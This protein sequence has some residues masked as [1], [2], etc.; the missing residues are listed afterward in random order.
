[1]PLRASWNAMARVAGRT[2]RSLRR[3]VDAGAR[4]PMVYAPAYELDLP[5]VPIDPLRGEK[6]LTALGEAGVISR[7]EIRAAPRASL[8]SLCR[9]HDANYVESLR[10][11][12]ALEGVMGVEVGE[13]A[14]QAIL[15]HQRHMVG[16]TALAAGIARSRGGLVVNVGGGLHH[17]HPGRGHGFCAFNDVAVAIGELRDRG[18]DLRVLVVDLDIH[19]G[20]GTRAFFRD[21][22]Q[23]HTFSIHNDHWG[24]T[25]AVESTSLAL[26]DGVTDQEYLATLRRHLPRV[27]DRFRPQL[28][29][30][31]AGADP[32][33]SD[34]L[35]NWDITDDG[36]LAR[37]RFVLG[38]LRSRRVE[39]V[40]WLFAGGY[41]G[42]AWRLSARSLL[43][44][45]TGEERPRVPS[46]EEVTLSR[47][48]WRAKLIDDRAL[49]GDLGDL[50]SFSEEDLLAGVEARARPRRY[51]GFY[52][53][54]GIELALERYGIFERLRKQGFDPHLEVELDE[55]IGDTLR[56]FGSAGR[57]ELL[58][59]LRS[60]RDRGTIP[61]MEVL[62]I[63]WMLLQNPRARWLA[64]RR[65]LP[66]QTYPGLGMF[67]DVLAMQVVV[68][69]RLGLD[70]IVVVPAH[71]HVAAQWRH[72]L[73]FLD[74]AVEGRFRALDE[75]LAG[76]DLGERVRLI[77]ARRVR[78]RDTDEP[79][80]YEP[81]VMVHPV[82]ERLD[83]LVH[84][85]DYESQA[86]LTQSEIELCVRS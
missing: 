34:G 36:M 67:A 23:V 84:E 20:D 56:I 19:D 24:D 73:R 22:P 69:E 32:A 85:P 63:E 70:G 48:R 50:L 71:Y 12:S 45:I 86:R 11:L 43:W 66:G 31:L 46:T 55:Q 6:V 29:F 38:L 75:A 41:G 79:C 83:G 5:G 14:A 9:V 35:G 4:V 17:A 33:A 76:R 44:A 53:I 82:S 80:I 54:H 21:D 3:I 64:G 25:R 52:T 7:G 2:W 18:H 37:D 60:R 57:E 78:H 59:E 42:D 30:F 77:E 15:D 13:R 74:P 47:Y 26:G 62:R 61:G 65:P 81:A 58:F 72:N 49:S 51:L 16:G 68:C 39:P 40:V 1:M 28:V 10:E 8:A 27:L